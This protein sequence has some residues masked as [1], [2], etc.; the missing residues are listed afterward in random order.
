MF[1]GNET[2]LK[3]YIYTNVRFKRKGLIKL[4]DIGPNRSKKIDL[5]KQFVF[6][7]T[8]I[9]LNITYTNKLYKLINFFI[10][11]CNNLYMNIIIV[12]GI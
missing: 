6:S 5:I 11:F 10:C 1:I 12:S 2:K 9:W 3:F 8:E 7:L 4:L